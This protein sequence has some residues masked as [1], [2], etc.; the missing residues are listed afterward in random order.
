MDGIIQ[1][2]QSCQGNI[3][4]LM[5]IFSTRRTSVYYV[6]QVLTFESF[7]RFTQWATPTTVFAEDSRSNHNITPYAL[8]LCRAPVVVFSWKYMET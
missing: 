6:V 5:S 7:N 8:T 3:F 1:K 4:F 2:T